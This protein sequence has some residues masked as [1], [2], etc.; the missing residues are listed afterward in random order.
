[1]QTVLNKALRFIHCN[2]EEQ[3]NSE[4]LHTKYNITPLIIS[5]YNKSLK[6][7][8]TIRI[9]EPEQYED[10]VTPHNNSHGWFLKSSSIISMEPPQAMII[11]QT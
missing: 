6:I 4:E 9:S 5:N 7:W 8:E 1:M 10:L 3:L 2:E 11:R